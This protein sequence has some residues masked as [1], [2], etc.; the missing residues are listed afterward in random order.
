[1]PHYAPATDA[2]T[3][4]MTPSEDTSFTNFLMQKAS[5]AEAIGY[6]PTQF[7]NMLGA[8][9]GSATV[10]KL[11]VKG[12]PSQ[13]FTRLWQLGRLDLTVEALIVETKWRL[14]INPILVQQAERMLAK[15]GYRFTPFSESTFTREIYQAPS[16]T[17]SQIAD[18]EVGG[19]GWSHDELRAAVA[20]YLDMQQLERVGSQFIKKKYYDALAEQFGRTTNSFEFRMQ[21]ISYVLSLM[22][23]AWLSGLKPARNVGANVA[24]QI[25]VLIAELEGTSIIPVVGFEIVVRDD[26]KKKLPQPPGSHKPKATTATVTQYQRDSSVKAWVLQQANGV[27]EC[28]SQQA[29]FAGSDGLPYLE[30]HH[31]RKLAEKGS[32]TTKNAVAVCPNCHREFHYGGQ[33]KQLVDK[34]YMTIPRL[35]RE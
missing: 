34:L 22:G 28:C 27:C 12:K 20:A 9:G 6:R 10:R 18:E 1:M 32:D 23:R 14:L 16:S 30:V 35:I 29:P 11:L 7:K 4:V 8:Q 24:A 26:M 19:E 33:A 25:E 21:N 17:N 2:E 15:S 31:V 13:G 5:E 3:I